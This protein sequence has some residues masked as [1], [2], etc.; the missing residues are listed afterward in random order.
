MTTADIPRGMSL[1]LW[2]P[3]LGLKGV[4]AEPRYRQLVLRSRPQSVQLHGSWRTLV[5]DG[6]ETAEQIQAHGLPVIL[7]IGADGESDESRALAP[8]R[9]AKVSE[10]AVKCG[11]VSVI[12]NAE[13]K[14]RAREPGWGW[15]EHDTEQIEEAYK[16][17]RDAAPGMPIG[18][19]SWARPDWAPWF[20]WTPFAGPGGCDYMLPQYYLPGA[21]L[22]GVQRHWQDCVVQW[23]RA[24]HGGLIREDL[25]IEAY[26]QA[27]G[28]THDTAG[29]VWISQKHNLCAFWVVGPAM[30]EDD[31]QTLEAACRLYQLGYHGVGPDGGTGISRWQ[32]AAGLYV[33]DHC[34]PKTLASLG[35]P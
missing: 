9:W 25:P 21:G 20:P 22:S 1:A 3:A 24:K 2:D 7:S 19:T 30:H 11:A 5:R 23:H 18:F 27:Y 35:V 10:A 32:A 29:A 26:A 8:E 16:A 6:P 34:G 15:T 14:T 31:R 33:D 13:G 28:A 12:I 4:W 17:M